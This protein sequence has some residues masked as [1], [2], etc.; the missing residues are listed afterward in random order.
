M[1]VPVYMLEDPKPLHL[2]SSALGLGSLC[3]YVSV[4]ESVSCYFVPQNTVS[5]CGKQRSFLFVV[6]FDLGSERTE[7]SMLCFGGM[8]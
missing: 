8:K 1:H 7:R 5:N 4:C 6:K 2:F 3:V